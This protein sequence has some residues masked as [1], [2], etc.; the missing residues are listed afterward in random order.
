MSMNEEELNEVRNLFSEVIEEFGDG[1]KSIFV[2]G[3]AARKELVQGSDIDILVI[4]DDNAD[5]Y[6]EEYHKSVDKALQV[7]KKKNKDRE[8][9]LHIQPAKTLS[10]WY[11]LL[12]KGVP[13]SI[14]AVKYSLPVYDPERFQSNL[15]DL[16]EASDPGSVTG[17]AEKL[18]ED[19]REYWEAAEDILKDAF[20]DVLR[21]V[22]HSAKTLLYYKNISEDGSVKEGLE[23][24]GGSSEA[25]KYIELS[26]KE[27]NIREKEG[28]PFFTDLESFSQDALKLIKDLQNIFEGD[29]KDFRN[30]VVDQAYE[31]V[32]GSCKII[33][34]KKDVSYTDE[35]VLDKFKEEFVESNKLDDNYWNILEDIEAQRNDKNVESAESVYRTVAGLR[36]FESALND[37][38]EIDLF[39]VYD[40]DQELTSS[41]ITPINEFEEMILENFETVKGVYVL[42]SENLLESDSA[43]VVLLVGEKEKTDLNNFVKDKKEEIYKEHGFKIYSDVETVSNFW[44]RIQAGDEELI[45]EVKSALIS[46]DH[47]G[48]LES[49][50]KLIERGEIEGTIPHVKNN[51][52]SSSVRA[53][54]PVKKAEKKCLEKYYKA[55]IKFG[56]AQIVKTG[57]DPPV[58]K[59]VPIVLEQNIDKIDGI[60]EDDVDLL[61]DVIRTYKDLEHGKEVEIDFESMD[62]IRREVKKIILR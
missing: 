13:W 43:N 59:K 6:D 51:I 57:S 7:L 14:T 2:Y 41:Q 60:R 10:S 30:K 54:L 37:F 25:E 58:Q 21:N 50:D 4:L 26:E 36:E 52:S 27:E 45:Y 20:S 28:Q 17:R 33:L 9:E 38:I 18:E 44:D 32:R 5:I 12:L 3:S 15:K 40:E 24:I 62:K 48:L 19:A 1:I 23:D 29:V 42:S 55:V 8:F 35:N 47:I 22:D 16:I 34:D 56:Q 49:L 11:S 46:Y 31:E 39:E 61:E 53:L